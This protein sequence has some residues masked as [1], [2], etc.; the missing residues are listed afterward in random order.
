MKHLN[1]KKTIH[2]KGYSDDKADELLLRH[3]AKLGHHWEK[4]NLINQNKA[5]KLIK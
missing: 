1:R 4:W 5:K 2:H 3:Y